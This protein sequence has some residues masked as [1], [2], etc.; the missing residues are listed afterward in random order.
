ML[1]G[2]ETERPGCRITR[3]QHRQCGYGAKPQREDQSVAGGPGK[4]IAQEAGWRATHVNSSVRTGKNDR[5]P[6]RAKRAA[7]VGDDQC[8]LP[9][10][11]SARIERPGLPSSWTT[12]PHNANPCPQ[13]KTPPSCDSGVDAAT[14]SLIASVEPGWAVRHRSRRC[15]GQA[16]SSTCRR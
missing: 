1:S 14:R 10:T 11:T 3:T 9:S 13:T 6:G 4:S 15:R 8:T 5:K 12:S 7:L 2:S 16:S